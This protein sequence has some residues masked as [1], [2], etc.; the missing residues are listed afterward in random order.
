MKLMQSFLEGN[1][2]EAQGYFIYITEDSIL[3]GSVGYSRAVLGTLK[4]PEQL[5]VQNAQLADKKILQ[6]VRERRNSKPNIKIFPLQ[7]TLDQKPN[8]KRM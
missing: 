7:L 3:S 4:L 2:Y 8:D 1:Y 5:P 6:N